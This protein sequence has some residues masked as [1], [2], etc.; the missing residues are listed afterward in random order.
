MEELLKTLQKNY[1]LPPEIFKRIMAQIID[2]AGY[3][4]KSVDKP[5]AVILGAQPGA[6]KTELQ[7]IAQQ[8]FF[9]NVVICNAD[10]FRDFHPLASEYKR[11][12]PVFFP[13][14]SAPVSHLW[15]LGLQKYC[16]INKYNY[17]LETTLQ[18]G[19]GINK[20]IQAIKDAGFKV[21][22]DILAVNDKV[23]YL[24]TEL[25]FEI[26]MKE[27]GSARFVGKQAH[28]VRYN[29][30]PGALSAILQTGGFDELNIYARNVVIYGDDK[31]SGVYLIAQNPSHPVEVYLGERNHSWSKHEIDYYATVAREILEMKVARNAPK[32]EIET[33]KNNMNINSSNIKR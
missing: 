13:E 16:R 11:K 6:G 31:R 17:V 18:S 29:A 26:M 28:D 12:Y 23:S 19:Q 10:N 5:T 15:T 2:E 9:N 14:I 24:G 21:Q 27:E 33:F 30:I 7:K 3:E 25:R 1:E 8:K 20:T 4:I 22:L 32:D